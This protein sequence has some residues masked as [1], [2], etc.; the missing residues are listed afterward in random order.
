MGNI[1]TRKRKGKGGKK[2]G[3]GRFPRETRC[4]HFQRA[5]R[6]S[7]TG[8]KLCGGRKMDRDVLGT[9]TWWWKSWFGASI[10]ERMRIRPVPGEI[11]MKYRAEETVT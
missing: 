10:L 6:V 1:H 8:E 4:R 7:V 11:S 2:R 3:E 9:H 5:R